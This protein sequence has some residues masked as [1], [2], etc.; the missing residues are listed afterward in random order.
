MRLDHVTNCIDVD[1]EVLVNEDVPEPADLR[2]RDLWVCIGNRC[3][4][5]IR[6]FADNLQVP[7]NRVLGHVSQVR[8]VAV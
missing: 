1:P 7:F 8:I 5:M 2:P 6:R 3:R 4:E